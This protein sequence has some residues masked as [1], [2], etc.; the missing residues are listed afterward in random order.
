MERRYVVARHAFGGIG[1]HLSCL[2]GS[3][4]LARRT[5][6]T[7]VIDWRGSRFSSDPFARRNCF[8]D[9]FELEDRLGGV[10]VIADDR[11]GEIAWPTPIYPPKWTSALL[12]SPVHMKHTTEEIVSVN[13]I[14]NGDEDPVEPTIVINQ[15][16]SPHP[17]KAV[18]GHLL[19]ELRPTAAIAADAERFWSTTFG[20]SRVIGIHVRHGN[21]ENI[22]HRAAYWLGPLALIRQ[23]HLNGTNDVHRPGLSGRFLDNMPDSL[24]GLESQRRYEGRF[25]R[26]IGAEFDRLARS[27][28]IDRALLFTD[29]PHVL[30][31]LEAFIPKLAGAPTK[32]L[33]AGA[34]PLHQ[35]D[36]KSVAT[37]AEG[38]ITNAGIDRGITHDM[39]VELELLRRCEGLI[40]MESGFTIFAQRQ[41]PDSHI[42]FLLPSATNQ[43]VMKAMSRLSSWG[44]R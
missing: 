36:G 13:R 17:P 11:V 34:G 25:Y 27:T 28:G 41:L 4:W 12:A 23:L 24:V 8:L 9:Y 15:W 1:D 43:L 3:W 30:Q 26:A 5:G 37:S 18:V 6:R 10:E 14:V 38:G 42:R 29:A 22:G 44:R 33:Q 20:S 32:L 21:G 39:F 16:I 31:G 40:C 2:I 35:L 19:A 7:L